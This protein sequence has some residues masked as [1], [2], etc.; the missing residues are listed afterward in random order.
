MNLESQD[1]EVDDVVRTYDVIKAAS[2]EMETW[3]AMNLDPLPVREVFATR[4]MTIARDSAGRLFRF[5]FNITVALGADSCFKIQMFAGAAAEDLA[6]AHD[7]VRKAKLGLFYGDMWEPHTFTIPERSEGW[8]MA[9][10][11]HEPGYEQTNELVRCNEPGCVSEYHVSIR[12]EEVLHETEGLSDPD[13]WYTVRAFKDGS[14]GWRAFFDV[15]ALDSLE[16]PEDL[17]ILERALNDYKWVLGEAEELNR[18]ARQNTT[19]K[20]A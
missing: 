17:P 1:A 16:G 7:I 15:T 9:R 18:A 6:R 13:G 4:K 14:S 8:I 2:P 19:R 10:A 20:A 11:F 12:G 5:A 3:A